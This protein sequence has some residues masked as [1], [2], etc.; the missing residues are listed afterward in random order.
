MAKNIQFIGVEIPTLAT[1]E[2]AVFKGLSN[3][4]EDSKARVL[5]LKTSLEQLYENEH[6]E[7]N[8][9]KIVTLPQLFFRARNGAYKI[10]TIVGNGLAKSENKNGL[11]GDLQELLMD[12]KWKNWIFN[13]GAIIAYSVDEELDEDEDEDE[14]EDDLK[15]EEA[16]DEKEEASTSDS[17][18]EL[19]RKAKHNDSLEKDETDEISYEEIGVDDSLDALLEK[20]KQNK[21]LE[22]EFEKRKAKKEEKSSEELTDDEEQV[23]ENKEDSDE[24][25]DAVE[26]DE[27]DEEVVCTE[28]HVSNEPIEVKDVFQ[29]SLVIEGGFGALRR[30]MSATNLIATPYKSE[31]KLDEDK[32]EELN[33]SVDLVPYEEGYLLDDECTIDHWRFIKGTGEI[34][35]DKLDVFKK[36]SKKNHLLELEY[37]LRNSKEKGVE[38]ISAIVSPVAIIEVAGISIAIDVCLEHMFEVTKKTMLGITDRKYKVN[39]KKMLPKGGVKAVKN[40]AKKGV[41]IHLVSSF[42]EKIHPSSI[43]A[44]TYGWVCNAIPLMSDDTTPFGMYIV[45]NSSFER[46]PEVELEII[47]DASAFYKVELDCKPVLVDE[48]EVKLNELFSVSKEEDCKMVSYVYSPVRL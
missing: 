29:F 16:S 11:L 2:E 34:D 41:D 37:T 28:D 38:P 30:A 8:A 26:S 13:M 17:L 15:K 44:K 22:E 4:V 33:T 27:I 47:E 42:G 35:E 10:E 39:L 1:S 20:A 18:D 24:E 48:E 43:L 14:K 21:I 45:Q 5:F 23:E 32:A 31:I 40:A 12:K 6:I 46:N 25:V 3:E 7:K 36:D 9:L 19:L